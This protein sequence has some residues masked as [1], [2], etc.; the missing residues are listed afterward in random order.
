MHGVPAAAVPG[1]A[2]GAPPPPPLKLL[3]VLGLARAALVVASA[4]PDAPELH[5]VLQLAERFRAEGLS[6]LEGMVGSALADLVRD[7]AVALGQP[8]AGALRGYAP[9]EDGLV[10]IVA[11]EATC[12]LALYATLRAP[13]HAQERELI[14]RL[15]HTT[16]A[17]DLARPLA[18]EEAGLRR[19]WLELVVAEQRRPADPAATDRT[20]AARADELSRAREREPLLSI[21][22]PS[23]ISAITR[24]R[25]AADRHRAW[26]AAAPPP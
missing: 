22:A 8:A 1:A 17:A 26:L 13:E 5:A 25:P 24:L 12:S 15:H 3:A 9:T 11:A 7:W 4:D 14:A 20:L 6:L 21:V 10:R 18:D 2:P 19:F 16:T 23:A